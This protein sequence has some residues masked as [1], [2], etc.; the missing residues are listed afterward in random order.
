MVKV[1]KEGGERREKTIGHAPP[2]FS[3]FI[4]KCGIGL[5]SWEG[6]ALAKVEVACMS[7]RKLVSR[8]QDKDVKLDKESSCQE[9]LQ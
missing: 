8:A 9:C 1:F 3:I 5:T 7:W 2:S 6:L 4:S